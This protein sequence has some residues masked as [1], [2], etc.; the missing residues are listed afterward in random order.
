M[1]TYSIS[2]FVDAKMDDYDLAHLR[3]IELALANPPPGSPAAAE[4]RRL[5]EHVRIADAQQFPYPEHPVTGALCACR[6]HCDGT[7]VCGCWCHDPRGL[8]P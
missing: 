2:V 4:L 6:V 8:P 7:V 1:N 3:L 5:T